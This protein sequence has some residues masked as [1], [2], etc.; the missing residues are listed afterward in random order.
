VPELPEL[1]ALARRLDAELPDRPIASVAVRSP[2]ILKTY[3]PPLDALV[4]DAFAAVRRRGKWLLLAT[5]AERTLAIHPMIGGRIRTTDGRSAPARPDALIVVFAD[6][7]DL[8]VAEIGPKKRA[9]VHFVPGD[10]ENLVAYLG[11]EPLDPSF[12]PARLA[13]I[14]A[15]SPHQIKVALV[16]QRTLAGLGN[17]WSDEVLHAA[18]VSPFAASARLTADQ[19]AALDEALAGCLAEGIARAAE[20][21]YLEKLKPDRR[22]YL[23]VHGRHGQP[24]PACQTPLAAIH[25]GERVTTYCPSCQAGGRVYA[26]RRL[27]RLLK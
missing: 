20:D 26:D 1:E 12:D 2:S 9:A 11:P 18:R 19:V 6:G 23:R 3:D 22:P 13:A 7:S 14:L 17:A 8:R 25:H 27:S 21:N 24:C 16:D 4:G 10:G 5:R 15:T